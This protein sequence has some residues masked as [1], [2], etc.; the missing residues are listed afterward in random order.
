MKAKLLEAKFS[1]L[2]EEINALKSQVSNHHKKKEKKFT[3]LKGL[4][5][6]KTHFTYEEIRKA[7][8]GTDT[9]L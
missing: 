6:N 4:W 9:R 1:S 8:I 2:L 7:E 5:K 3:S